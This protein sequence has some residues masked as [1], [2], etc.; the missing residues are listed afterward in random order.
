MGVLIDLT[1]QRFGS[2]TVVGRSPNRKGGHGDDAY[3]RCLC[4]CGN[5]VDKSSYGLRHGKHP[6]CGCVQARG[7]SA[8]CLTIKAGDRFGRLTVVGRATPIGQKPV[9]WLC[10]CDCGNTNEV[11]TYRLKSGETTSCGCVH[12][13][14]LA[15]R[16]R[17][18]GQTGTRLYNI[19]RGMKS[20]CDNPHAT[21]YRYYGAKGIKVCEEWASDF[22]AFAEWSFANGYDPDLPRKDCTIDR[23]D[24]NGDY[25]PSNCRWVDMT[26]QNRNKPK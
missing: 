8:R 21:S 15:E 22:D 12:S 6:S 20:R 7:T 23:I 14:M 3:W 4:D 10:M 5:Y 1:G 19:W 13:E 9:R 18:H 16:N 11:E 26:V 24:P 2:L 17:V 25:C